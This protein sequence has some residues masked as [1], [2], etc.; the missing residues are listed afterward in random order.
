MEVLFLVAIAF[1]AACMGAAGQQL[2]I[3][4]EGKYK[5]ATTVAWFI[6]FL[7]TVLLIIWET[8]LIT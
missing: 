7:L 6:F 1:S 4:T 8:I 5:D 2:R 3:V